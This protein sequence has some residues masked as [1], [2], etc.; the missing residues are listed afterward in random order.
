MD[1]IF[2]LASPLSPGSRIPAW[3]MRASFEVPADYATI[4]AAIDSATH[5]DEIVV[6]TGTYVETLFMRVRTFISG[7]PPPFPN[8]QS[9]SR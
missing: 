8:G 6:A 1:P 5:G 3:F 4:Q 9:G 2:S 7:R